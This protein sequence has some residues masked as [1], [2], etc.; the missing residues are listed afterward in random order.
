MNGSQNVYSEMNNNRKGRS[1][2]HHG[3]VLAMGRKLN[4]MNQVV[5]NTD[6]GLSDTDFFFK[7]LHKT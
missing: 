1:L 5:L 3:V 6:C 2:V 7:D 4:G